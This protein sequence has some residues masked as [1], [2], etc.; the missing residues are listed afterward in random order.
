MKNKIAGPE[1]PNFESFFLRSNIYIN[2]AEGFLFFQGSEKDVTRKQG[3]ASLD[4]EFD[5]KSP[6]YYEVLEDHLKEQYKE[7]IESEESKPTDQLVDKGNQ[8]C[9]TIVD[10]FDSL[11]IEQNNV[12][13]NEI[14][15]NKGWFSVFQNSVLTF[16]IF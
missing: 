7:I 10:K 15:T 5:L 3:E 4:Y 16:S 6:K 14:L 2:S 1:K 11:E 8:S 12:K 13:N 9:E